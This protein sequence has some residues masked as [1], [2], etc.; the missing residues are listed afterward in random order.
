MQMPVI[1]DEYPNP[2]GYSVYPRSHIEIDYLTQD[3][4]DQL[5][6]FLTTTMRHESPSI[7]MAVGD[8]SI[9][10]VLSN[11]TEDLAK[12]YKIYGRHSRS[13]FRRWARH[14]H[15]KALRKTQEFLDALPPPI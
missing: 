14:V 5:V 3:Q 10:K 15:P 2:W 4:A 11:K 9:L 12:S 8:P 13:A 1:V 6:A 7:L